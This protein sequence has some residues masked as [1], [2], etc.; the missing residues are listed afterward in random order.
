MTTWMD[1]QMSPEL[2]DGLTR[3]FQDEEE[4]LLQRLAMAEALRTSNAQKRT[5]AL[6]AGLAGLGDVLGAGVAGYQQGEVVDEQRALS[7]D[8][9]TAAK[10]AYGHLS[11]QQRALLAALEQAGGAP[12]RG[13]AQAPAGLTLFPE[14]F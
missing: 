3:P 4:M 8:K 9:Q 6:G 12:Q 10:G 7:R 14:G 2:Q 1:P 5:T 13:V 11:A